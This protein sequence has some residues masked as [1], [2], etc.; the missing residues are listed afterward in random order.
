[1]FTRRFFAVALIA[2]VGAGLGTV[3]ARAADK[4]FQ[5][6]IYPDAKDEFRWRL[7]DGDGGIVATSGDGYKRKADCKKM[8][9]NIKADIGKYTFEV[10]ED[11]KKEYRFRLKAN[12]GNIIAASSRSQKTK[13][14]AD[15]LTE[16]I[17]KEVKNADVKEVEKAD[18]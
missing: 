11:A 12:N 17:S 6:E 5:F 10:Y 8:V 7:R 1:M 18:K 13:A 2:A 16:T 14:D 9:E 15:K 4:K 3:H